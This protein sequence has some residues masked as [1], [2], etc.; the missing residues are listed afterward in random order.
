MPQYEKFVNKIME[1]K[2]HLVDKNSED[3]FDIDQEESAPYSIYTL[4]AQFVFAGAR[5]PKVDRHIP[6]D[7]I[8]RVLIDELGD[9]CNVESIIDDYLKKEAEGEG[10]HLS[11]DTTG[12]ELEAMLQ[13]D[14]SETIQQMMEKKRQKIVEKREK[15]DV[16]DFEDLI[17]YEK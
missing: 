9:R 2:L 16:S 1:A 7:E 6:I 8:K 10:V 4:M 3:F 15:Y 13:Q 5:N 12:D 14:A 17:Y 11:K